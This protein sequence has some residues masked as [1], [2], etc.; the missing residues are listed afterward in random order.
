VKQELL[1]K[2][3]PDAIPDLTA[4]PV[5]TVEPRPRRFHQPITVT[6]PLPPGSSLLKETNQKQ[7]HSES[8]R[9]LCSISGE[10]SNCR[11]F[12]T[13]RKP[14][15]ISYFRKSVNDMEIQRATFCR[16][17]EKLPVQGR[18]RAAIFLTLDL[19]IV[20]DMNGLYE[21]AWQR[22]VR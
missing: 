19:F 2:I 7:T 5:V 4:S 16:V 11:V 8:L 18:F 14:F 1:A 6:I 3:L 22:A 15:L 13:G 20:T 10:C 21:C 17:S 12:I 9:L